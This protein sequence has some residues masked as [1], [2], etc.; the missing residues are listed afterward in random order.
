MTT[1]RPASTAQLCWSCQNAVPTEDG[2]RGCEWSLDFRPVPGW[3][4][5][6]VGKSVIGKTW[7]VKA[8]PK[9]IPDR[10]RKEWPY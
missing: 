1:N 2:R 9:Y 10:P 7:S 4:A 8:C 6:R 5:E 3:T